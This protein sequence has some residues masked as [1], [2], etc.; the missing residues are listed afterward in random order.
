[1]NTTM[2]S[3]LEIEARAGAWLARRESGDWSA[4]EQARLAQW[5]EA[6]TANRVAYLRQEAAWECALRLQALKGSTPDGEVPSLENWRLTPFVS[7]GRAPKSRRWRIPDVRRLAVAA[8][9]AFLAITL[10]IGAWMWL[11]RRPSAYKTPVGVTAAVPLPDGSQVT[12]NTDSEIQVAV[13]ETERRIDL[14]RGE[15]FFIVA[16][17]PERPFIVTAG[18]KRVVAVGTAFS[19][20]RHGE[21][22]RVLVTEGKVRIEEDT[23]VTAGGIARAGEAGVVVR[24]D[25]LVQIE[26]YL[27][28]RSGYLIFRETPLR[29][30]VEEFNRYNAQ[31]ILIT[32]PRVADLRFS[33]KIRPT[34]VEP[35]IRLLEE[36]FP[37][38][39][40]RAGRKILLT[41]TN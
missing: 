18:G 30:A 36:S 21:D 41:S 26:D 3:S 35:F 20:R 22:I 8:S 29:E 17:D 33:G 1:M 37:V 2:E 13:T 11:D 5:L 28:W 4:E 15:A 38:R 14:K 23:F 16:K 31:K 9:V 19:V 39:A 25:T 40:Q 32:G 6:S 27:S 24:Q 10:G 7:D 34:S 12:L